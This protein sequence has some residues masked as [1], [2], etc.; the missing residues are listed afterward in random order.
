MWDYLYI[1]NGKGEK[2][3]DD[4]DRWSMIDDWWLM[5]DDWWWLMID[6]WWLMM[7][8]DWWWLMI[9]DDW[10]WLMINDWWLMVMI[11][12]WWR[13]ANPPTSLQHLQYVRLPVDVDRCD[14]EVKLFWIFGLTFV[15]LVC[16]LI[17][18][19][20]SRCNDDVV[21]DLNWFDCVCC[22]PEKGHVRYVVIEI[23]M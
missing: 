9:D 19:S 6:D 16:S 13:T 20:S 8:D 22:T 15:S 11:D 14:D 23:D 12:D 21:L 17:R 10:W 2:V 18:I 3:E 4:D 1:F 7:I 5:I